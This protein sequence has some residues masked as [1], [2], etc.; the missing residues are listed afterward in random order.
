[1]KAFNAPELISKTNNH[2]S[3]FLAGSIDMGESENWQDIFILNYNH[4]SINFYNPRRKEWDSSWEQRFDSPEFFQ[5][6]SWELDAMDK[7]DI[8]VMNIL[9][10]SKSPI[11]LLELGLYANTNKLV[12]CCP[13]KF[14]RS[15]NVH[16]VCNKYNI[17]LYK[18][19]YSFRANSIH[20]FNSKKH[21]I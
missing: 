12:V 20:N 16:I 15:G 14:Y 1:M 7:A 5:Q 13:D 8:I 4:L 6:V 21:V 9:P 2:Q 11:T 17:P 3:V 10:N 18:D 19:F